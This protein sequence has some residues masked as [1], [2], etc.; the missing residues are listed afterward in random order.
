MDIKTQIE[1]DNLTVEVVRASPTK[2]L[3]ILSAGLMITTPEG[4]TKPKFQVSIDTKDLQW[5]PNK[6]S[7]KAIA[8]GL[9]TETIQWVGKEVTLEIQNI[10]GK[11][12]VIA[13]VPVLK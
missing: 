5:I 4:K 2:K 10:K 1:G 8:G 6:M 9:G 7:L 11:D 13:S 12:C 3:I